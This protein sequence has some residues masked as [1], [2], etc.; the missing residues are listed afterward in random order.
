MKKLLFILLAL[1]MVNCTKDDNDD[2]DL[3]TYNSDLTITEN[4]DNGVP[5]L[6]ITTQIGVEAFYGLEYGGGYIFY[7]DETDG[8]IMVATDYS[9]IG[10]TSWGDHFDLTNST[11]IGG[12][13]E[14]TQQIVDGNLADNSTVPN[15]FE[16]GSDDYAF[17]IAYDLEFNSHDD[18]FIPSSGSMK[19]IFD[20]VHSRGMGN[21]DENVF[22]WSSSK[23]GY[24]PYVMSFNASFFGGETFL[25]SCFN[26]NSVLL[27]RKF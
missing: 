7:V 21:F 19:A 10:P 26:T 11:S 4:L 1:A 2:I 24:N 9:S 27:V 8:T 23:V 16:F 6:D 18:W 5:V 12:G 14:N 13:L 25:G 17:K 15:G 3:T 22:Y 20:N